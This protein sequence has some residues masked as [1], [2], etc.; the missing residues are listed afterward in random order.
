MSPMFVDSFPFDI[1]EDDFFAVDTGLGENLTTRRD[2][3]ALAPELDP[4]STGRRFVTDA[5]DCGDETADSRSRDCAASFP[6]PNAGH[7]HTWL[8]PT[9]ASRSRLDKEDLGAS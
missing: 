6:R 5:I 9:D 4:I 7:N 1:G 3:E 8:S 2:D